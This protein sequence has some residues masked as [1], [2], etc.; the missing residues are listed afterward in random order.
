MF[1]YIVRKAKLEDLDMLGV[2]FDQYRIFYCKES[3]LER[4]KKILKERIINNDSLILVADSNNDL[5]GY[6]QLFPLFSSTKM[7]RIWLLNDLFIAEKFRGK[8]ISKKLLQASVDF[9]KDNGT[10]ALW[11]ETEH[12]NHIANQLYRSAKWELDATHHYYHL[13]LK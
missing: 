6:V 11:L 13:H 8:G 10:Y 7:E 9:G 12:S 4:G 2:L 3:D 1:N 5:V